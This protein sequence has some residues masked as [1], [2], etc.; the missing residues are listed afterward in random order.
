[1]RG[2]SRKFYG[3]SS[4]KARA[5][6][7]ALDSRTRGFTRGPVD[8][9]PRF[10]ICPTCRRQVEYVDRCLRCSSRRGT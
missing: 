1:M 9:T 10:K 4:A 8:T 2:M 6:P 5:N 3:G 7:A